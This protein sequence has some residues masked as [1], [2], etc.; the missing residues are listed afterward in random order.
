MQINRPRFLKNLADM[1]ATGL[2][3]ETEGGGRD[4]R[5]FSPADRAARDLFRTLAAEAGLSVHL[6]TA[7][8]LSARL[9]C[10]PE[11]AKTL[12]MG[13]HL[14]TVPHGGPY[15]GAL[16]VMA[17]LEVLMVVKDGGISL[18]FHLE[19]V[20]FTDE[21]GRFGDFFGSRSLAGAHAED[22]VPRFLTRA[23]RYPEDLAAMRA[24]Q[25]G[26]LTP[27]TV[28]AAA[29]DPGTL[30]GYLELHIEQGPRLEHAG[31]PIGLVTAIYGRRSQRVRFHGRPDHAG[32]TPLLL[33]ADALVAASRF[34]A[35]APEIVGHRFPEAV[36]TCGGVE[37]SPGVTNVVPGEATILLEFRAATAA[38]LDGIAGALAKLAADVTASADLA[39]TFLPGSEHPPVPM[40]PELQ[41]AVR[42][43]LE[44]AGLAALDMPSG[45]GHDAL[46]L[47]EITPAA[48][49]FVP[50][51][52]GRSHCPDETTSPDDLVAG[53]E[54]LLA[55]VL[56]YGNR[57]ARSGR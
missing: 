2:L 28:P 22:S 34:I 4:R 37:V 5:P 46:V 14:D 19:A 26:I 42:Q 8:N 43:G 50:S 48:M 20:D 33:R 54:A 56:A 3:P 32:T 16:G 36:V 57:S 49:L 51:V 11:G 17:A 23:A 12:L 25:P 9:D 45:A 18:P 53:A 41:D 1:A 13:S 35:G 39:Y 15:D 24:Q 40:D 38:E 21:E 47:A 7:A 44:S 10:G 30:A 27:E 52:G 31:I 55:A 29:R 6:D